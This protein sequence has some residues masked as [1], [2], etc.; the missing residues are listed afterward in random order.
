MAAGELPARDRVDGGL[1]AERRE[2]EAAYLEVSRSAFLLTRHMGRGTDEA[3][4]IVQDAALR[5]WRYRSSR[6][7]EFRPWFLAIVYRLSRSRRPEWLPLPSTWDATA[8]NPID[9]NLDPDLVDALRL[10]PARQRAAL[11][12]RYCDDLSTAEV[13]RIVG[14]SESA[15]KQLLMRSRDALRARLTRP[16]EEVK[17]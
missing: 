8:P 13:A 15:A 11:W 1:S 3:T 4:D 16:Q 10:L 7:G 17:T 9:R 14:C 6:S 2:F 5:A 12:L